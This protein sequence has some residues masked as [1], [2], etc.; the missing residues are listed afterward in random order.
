MSLDSESL[1]EDDDPDDPDDDLDLDDEREDDDDDDEDEDDDDEDEEDEEDDE[2]ERDDE[3]DERDDVLLR[4][5]LDFSVGVFAFKSS[6][7][8]K[9]SGS[10]GSPS[11]FTP[12]FLSM[13]RS[14][15]TSR[16]ARSR[17]LYALYSESRRRRSSHLVPLSKSPSFPF[18]SKSS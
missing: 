2:D 8:L 1:D 3:R 7:E 6:S 14:N 17:S 15:T 13:K 10:V 18:L 16:D 5:L 11:R 4:F 9:P 12:N